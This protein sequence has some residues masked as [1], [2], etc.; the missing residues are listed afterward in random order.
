MHSRYYIYADL[1]PRKISSLSLLVDGDLLAVYSD[2]ILASLYG[3]LA[4]TDV[5][6]VSALC[7]IVF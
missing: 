7:G 3:V 5:T 4:L 1:S 2:G 6:C